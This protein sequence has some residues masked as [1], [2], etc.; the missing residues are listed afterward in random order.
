M[1]TGHAIGPSS[2]DTSRFLD[3]SAIRLVYDQVDG[4]IGGAIAAS[5][6]N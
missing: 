3:R 4:A 2:H 6:S 5:L 1:L